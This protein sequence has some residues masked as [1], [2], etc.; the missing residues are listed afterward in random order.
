MSERFSDRMQ[1]IL[2]SIVEVAPL[3]V[4]G[5]RLAE[6]ALDLTRADYAAIGA[7]D[8]RDQLEQWVPV[9]VDPAH[10]R[11]MGHPP[12]GRGLL[13][14]FARTSA[15]ILLDDAAQYPTATGMPEHH[16]PM[17]P[18]LGVP[19]VYAGHSIGAFYVTRAPGGAPFTEDDQQ[20]LADLAPYAA[21]A[22][23]NARAFEREQ[24]RAQAA[25]AL[26]RAAADLRE[27]PDEREVAAV[28]MRTL[29][30]LFESSPCAAVTWSADPARPYRHVLESSAGQLAA[31][32]ESSLRTD[33]P[34]GAHR[35]S[36]LLE[37]EEAA[38]QLAGDETGRVALAVATAA[39]SVDLDMSP[40]RELAALGSD[41]LAAIRR[42]AAEA[43]LERYALRDEIARD[44]HDD[45]IQS[46]YAIGL[47]MRVAAGGDAEQL[48]A[49]LATA[50][51]GLNEVIRELRAYIAQLSHGPESIGNSGLLS[52]RIAALLR[53]PER[54]KWSHRIELGRAPLA[55]DLERQ[56]Y[57]IVREAVSNVQRHAHAERASL[58]LTVEDR[59]LRLAVH[60]DGVGFDRHDIR[61]GAVGLRSVEERVVSLGGSVMIETQPGRG[62]T[63][64]AT[65][66]LAPAPDAGTAEV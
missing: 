55:P 61:E 40:L 6:A 58:A 48:R 66:P 46:I 1:A 22:M 3:A 53:G 35:R 57:L 63:I 17:G 24:R 41:S 12:V 54:P 50:S 8:S 65:F 38:L 37:G 15:P 19:V 42:Q 4:V 43:S 14:A 47:G 64:T 9:G 29:G 59:A 20:R 49:V 26:Q 28:L 31:S 44:L 2:L 62:T 39:L 33:L 18:F 23:A 51:D 16:P 13:G 45:L 11:L 56:L 52:A 10:E 34:N 7:Y 60:D 32:L 21:L 27:A 30:A 5:R 25:E 36:D